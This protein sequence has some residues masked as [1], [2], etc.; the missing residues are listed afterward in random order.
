ML[1]PAL[2]LQLQNQLAIASAATLEYFSPRSSV[3]EPVEDSIEAAQG[4][5][6]RTEEWREAPVVRDG[7]GQFA[8]KPKETETEEAA[9]ASNSIDKILQEKATTF[10]AGLKR[11]ER[12]QVEKVNKTI[13]DRSTDRLRELT[14]GRKELAGELVEMMFGKYAKEARKQL[15][16]LC[17]PINPELGKAVEEDPYQEVSA[18]IKRL[19]RQASLGNTKALVRD[20]PKAFQYTVAKYNKT[21][22]DLQNATGD[23]AELMHA[24]GKAI[25]LT[26]PITT[27]LAA[28]FGAAAVAGV[29]TH[30]IAVAPIFAAGGAA[31]GAAKLA[32]GV[33][34]GTAAWKVKSKSIEE[35]LDILEID[36]KVTRKLLKWSTFLAGDLS[37]LPGSLS[38]P[39]T[40]YEPSSAAAALAGLGGAAKA[41]FMGV[42]N[43]TGIDLMNF[44]VF[45]TLNGI[46]GDKLAPGR[47]LS[48]KSY[49]QVR[50]VKRTRDK[51]EKKLKEIQEKAQAY[52][53]QFEQAMQALQQ[54]PD[55]EEA[56]T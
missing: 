25:A 43:V 8:S 49:S 34:V 46:L 29:L 42:I 12:E 51:A 33:L 31:A 5:V 53:E 6:E 23:N 24:T 18:D 52:N 22:D 1:N 21:V 9:P 3:V 10:S 37:Q 39:S 7:S 17:K 45:P 50:E 11:F 26:V 38:V 35:G 20:L 48:G 28:S 13:L 56:P 40:L 32:T 44:A 19:Q 14:E 41:A 47:D 15:S 55:L 16:A 30:A 54:L 4:L 27:F 36:N 2:L